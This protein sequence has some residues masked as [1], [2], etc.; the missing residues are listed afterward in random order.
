MK[1]QPD[2]S[3]PAVIPP[4]AK[5]LKRGLIGAAVL[6]AVALIYGGYWSFLAGHFKTGIDQWTA[7]RRAEGYEAGY[8]SVRVEGFPFRLR[9]EITDPY[10]AAPRDGEGGDG[11]RPWSWRGPAMVLKV[12]PWRL[13]RIRVMAPGRH[14]IMGFRAGRPVDY[15]LEARELWLK[16]KYR[17]DR[18]ERAALSVRG[19]G[20]KEGA[21]VDV[22]G[23][24]AADIIVEM[25]KTPWAGKDDLSPPGALALTVEAEDVIFPFEPVRGLG[26]KTARLGVRSTVT[27][28]IAGLL[29]RHA[30]GDRTARVEA[31]TRWRDSSGALEVRRLDFR[32]G[33]LVVDGDG[34]LAL[35][36]DLQPIGSFTFRVQGFNEALDRLLKA[37][38]IEPHPAALVKTVLAALARKTGD[39]GAQ[40]KVPL[41]LQDR[42]VFVGPIP[43][44]KIPVIRWP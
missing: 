15:A 29:T 37:G 11:V 21:G 28:D 22:G 33:P 4:A 24:A 12:R 25:A 31:I 26:R 5:G 20:V 7:E 2:N 9:V 8:S 32:H 3:K 39:G 27:G 42:Q 43:M 6:A 38:L 14:R 17:G 23:L 35:D 34:T 13:S 40:L 1:N 30:L 44:A 16:L 18:P 10:L 41:S 36:G 19:L